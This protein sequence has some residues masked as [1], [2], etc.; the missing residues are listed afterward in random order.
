MR[1]QIQTRRLLKGFLQSTR[2]LISAKADKNIRNNDGRAPIHLAVRAGDRGMVNLLITSGAEVDIL[3]ASGLGKTDLISKMVTKRSKLLRATDKQGNTPLHWAS[4]CGQAMAVRLLLQLGAERNA[5]NAVSLAPI[6][7][8][9][10]EGHDL[11]RDMLLA[12]NVELDIWAAA[13]LNKSVRI[14]EIIKSAPSSVNDADG[15]GGTALHWA[16][17]FEAKDALKLLILSGA[18]VNRKDK[19]GRTPLHTGAEEGHVSLAGE[20]ID[21]K[22]D[23]NATDSRKR[24][25]LHLAARAGRADI[26]RLLIK[27]G[28]DVDNKDEEGQTPLHLAAEKGSM[29]V[30]KVLLANGADVNVRDNTEMTPAVWAEVNGHEDLARLLKEKERVEK[31]PE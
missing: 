14:K 18:D 11:V 24:T 2:I 5:R 13:A 16:V 1:R 25:P 7:L 31:S 27:R 12:E 8:A 17:S 29:S 4:W 26:V 3:A 28:A 10:A 6:H 21:S 19:S 30:A 15:L 22:A 9:I 20:L 23:V